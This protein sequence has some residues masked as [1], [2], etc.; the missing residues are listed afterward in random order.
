MESFVFFRK[1]KEEEKKEDNLK[2]CAM[3]NTHFIDIS[4]GKLIILTRNIFFYIKAVIETKKNKNL[5]HK[6]KTSEKLS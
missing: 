6:V 1:R 5:K 4:N 2:K 3:K